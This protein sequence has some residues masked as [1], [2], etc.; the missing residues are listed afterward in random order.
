MLSEVGSF[1]NSFLV[2][3]SCFFSFAFYVSLG[4]SVL[5]VVFY[6]EDAKTVLFI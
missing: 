6:I 4:A 2:P 5:L 1:K 3:P